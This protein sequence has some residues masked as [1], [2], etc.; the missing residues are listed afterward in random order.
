MRLRY[1]SSSTAV[2]AATT[3]QQPHPMIMDGTEKDEDEGNWKR[4]LQDLL[5]DPH[6]KSISIDGTILFNRYLILF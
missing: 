3:I 2:K 1:L 4:E 5:H 6:K